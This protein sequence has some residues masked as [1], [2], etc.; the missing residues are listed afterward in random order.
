MSNEKGDNLIPIIVSN[1]YLKKFYL[2]KR[3]SSLPKEVKDTIKVI[4]VKLTE[5]VGGVIEASFDMKLYD[6]RFFA[7]HNDDDF[8][9]DEINAN[10]KLSRMENEYSELFSDVAKFCKFK[11]SGLV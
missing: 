5:E 8:N 10:Y 11:L 9:Y 1:S 2:D 4:F 3:L 7:Y 6:I